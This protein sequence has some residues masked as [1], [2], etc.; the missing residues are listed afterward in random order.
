MN[1]WLRQWPKL[2]QSIMVMQILI[3]SLFS[4]TWLLLNSVIFIKWVEGFGDF[5]NSNYGE[6][7]WVT[8]KN[9]EKRRRVERNFRNHK[10]TWDI[11]SAGVRAAH[12]LSMEGSSPLITIVQVSGT[13]RLSDT[14]LDLLHGSLEFL[15]CK[16]PWKRKKNVLHIFSSVQQGNKIQT[17]YVSGMEEDLS[18]CFS[19]FHWSLL[20]NNI[21]AFFS[22]FWNIPIIPLIRKTEIRRIPC[23]QNTQHGIS[24]SLDD[25]ALLC[26]E[27]IHFKDISWQIYIDIFA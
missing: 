10:G 19:F 6:H 27:E 22:V 15:C 12:G 4:H 1:A 9:R 5:N 23:T 26:K 18:I 17:S 2:W 3:R 20:K 16:S 11:S 21:Y 13:L 14:R 25:L 24:C 8:Q 7:D